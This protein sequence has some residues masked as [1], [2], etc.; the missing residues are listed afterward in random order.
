MGHSG[1]PWFE[2]FATC[3]MGHFEP[4][5][6]IPVVARYGSK[7]RGTRNRYAFG[8]HPYRVCVPQAHSHFYAESGSGPL[9]LHFL[10]SQRSTRPCRGLHLSDKKAI[11]LY[12]CVLLQT[13]AMPIV[14][15]QGNL[16]KTRPEEYSFFDPSW[17]SWHIQEFPSICASVLRHLNSRSDSVRHFKSCRP[18]RRLVRT[19]TRYGY[20]TVQ[21]CP[22]VY[23][24]NI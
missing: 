16:R 21:L 8:T 5:H 23:Y 18:V 20:R 12:D 13:D 17:L 3:K 14:M 10:T 4:P 6:G 22:M 15:R 1:W 11:G 24:Q 2:G 9:R 19:R 7:F